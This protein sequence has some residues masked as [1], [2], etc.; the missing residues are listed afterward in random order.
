MIA[1][2]CVLELAEAFGTVPSQVFTRRGLLLCSMPLQYT[3]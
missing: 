2:L 1:R 3:Q